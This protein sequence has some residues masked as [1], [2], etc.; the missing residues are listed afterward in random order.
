MPPQVRREISDAKLP[1]GRPVVPPGLAACRKA[2]FER[3]RPA[4]VLGEEFLQRNGV[5]IMQRVEQVAVRREQVRLEGYSPAVF[6]EG[7]L[8]SPAGHEQDAHVVVRFGPLRLDFREPFEGAIAAR[9]ARRSY[10]CSPG[11]GEPRHARGRSSGR[12][13]MR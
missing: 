8:G 7:I 5:G 1:L 13:P 2:Q 10:E 12:I 11:C 3:R 6:C 4:E 9:T